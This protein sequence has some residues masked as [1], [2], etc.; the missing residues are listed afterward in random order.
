MRHNVGTY[1][2]QHHLALIALFVALG[3]TSYA[4]VSGIPGSDGQLHGCYSK[5]S[6]SLRLVKSG[7]KC[8]KGEKAIAWSQRGA[9]GVAGASGATGATGAGGPQ[10]P[11]GPS[12]AFAASRVDGPAISV[13]ADTPV[14]TLANLPAGNYAIVAKT[15]VH[16]SANTDVLCTLVAG[17]DTDVA[18]SFVGPAGVGG[19]VFV[20]VLTTELVH[21][22]P[23]AGPAQLICTRDLASTVTFSNTKIIATRVGSATNTAVTG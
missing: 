16:A 15:E 13:T 21:S 10:G 9:R 8:R 4:A 18:E 19:A 20:D 12:D 7:K 2:R 17:A 1:L 11:V 23:A 22:F 5:S 14:A 3:G 6:G